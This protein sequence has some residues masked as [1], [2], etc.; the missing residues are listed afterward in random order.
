M[1]RYEVLVLAIPV[2]TQDEIKS[3]QSYFEAVAKDLNGVVLSFEKWGKYKLAYDIRHNAE[4]YEYGIYILVRFDMPNA[5]N[6]TQKIGD[7]ITLKMGNLILRHMVS[8]LDVR[9]SLL[10]QR[11]QSLE[12][13]PMTH[14]A[15]S[16]VRGPARTPFVGEIRESESE[17]EASV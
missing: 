15:D 14:P 16:H 9:Q 8:R 10:Y 4:R 11:P 2:I 5:A 13:A 12:E 1:C 6:F 17:T 3:L 7:V